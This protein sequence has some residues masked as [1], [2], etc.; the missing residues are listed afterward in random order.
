MSLPAVVF[1]QLR[2]WL[3]WVHSLVCSTP[4]AVVTAH[5]GIMI[6]MILHS[7]GS[8][9]TSSRGFCWG[10]SFYGFY[11]GGMNEQAVQPGCVC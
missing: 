9:S 2:G 11:E 8:I 4:A 3:G 10:R 6:S 5:Y 7:C 1:G